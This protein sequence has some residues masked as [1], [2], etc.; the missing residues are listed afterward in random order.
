VPE[1]PVAK[2]TQLIKAA[3]KTRPEAEALK[4]EARVQ[5]A[6]QLRDVWA[7]GEGEAGAIRALGTL[8]GE[9]PKPKFE[10]PRPEF[11]QGDIDGLYNRIAE[12]TFIVRGQ[13]SAFKAVP[14]QS[15][16]TKLLRGQLPTMGE[17]QGL[18][19]VFG[20]E[21]A[22][23]VRSRLPLGNRAWREF[24]ELSGLARGVQ[25]AFD[26]SYGL[27]Q[28]IVA[29]PRHP[30]A[31]MNMWKEGFRQF[32]PVIEIRG[33]QPLRKLT[34][35]IGE[36]RGAERLAYWEGERAAGNI[37]QNLFVAEWGPGAA[38]TEREEVF[39]SRFLDYVPGIR[40]SNR[41][42]SGMGNELR[43]R[44]SQGVVN[45]WR[46]Q[47]LEIT[48]QMM[49]DLGKGIN[50]LS[51][52]GPIPDNLGQV[53]SGIFYAPRFV[54]SKPA[55]I[56]L[57]LNPSTS[58]QVRSMIA[59]EFV[60]FVGT[61]LGILSMVKLSGL[62][63]VE[64][65]PRSSDFGKIRLG[66]LRYDFWGGTQ[67]MARYA[68]QLITG[69]RKTIGTGELVNA[70]RQA[71]LGRFVQSKLSPQAGLGLDVWRGETF[72]GED[73]E[74]TPGSIKTQAWNRAAPMFI[75]DVVDAVK[76]H[77]ASAGI[78]APLSFFGAGV[79]AMWTPGQ[80]VNALTR[81]YDPQGRSVQEMS[82]VE[83][84]RLAAE[85]PD[86]AAARTKQTEASAAWGSEIAVGKQ[87]QT[88][89]DATFQTQFLERWRDPQGMTRSNFTDA[90]SDYLQARAQRNEVRY[91]GMD[92]DPRTDLE[93]RLDEYYGAKLPAVATPTEREQF[94]A[95]QDALLAADP[96]LALAIKDNQRL[97]FTDPAMQ[98]VVGQIWDAK[99]T[100]KQYY[101]IPAFVGLSADEADQVT[102]IV[103][104]A[105]DMATYGQA[106]SREAAIM[107]LAGQ[108][109][110]KFIMYALQ[111]EKLRNP[112]RKIFKMQHA[113]E[114]SWFSDLPVE[115]VD[116]FA[117]AGVS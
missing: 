12:H 84:K 115:G 19:E 46:R 82:A 70:S 66:K 8:K 93:R 55:W 10:P 79:Q 53:L 67:Q 45:G 81:K 117:M 14:V 87:E 5:Q 77:G 54:T 57:A 80:Q 40:M 59:Q 85:H 74:V 109:P 69:Q 104:Q 39:I 21:F 33:W 42:F 60:A 34:P 20:K 35:Y 7:A 88:A 1:D 36:A 65:D 52:R 23:A 96:E 72:M 111:A 114:L 2:L 68:A 27:R 71:V 11:G 112:E 91:A 94:F 107:L 64:A 9:L 38:F 47:G 101:A 50:Y 56:T 25:A 99:Q 29:A 106:P 110:Q 62:G 18:E 48:D 44:I 49:T 92:R 3:R 22:T 90:L 116:T 31:W 6:G 105:S 24:W 58:P 26:M 4:H 95:R 83:F 75:Q 61:G 78:G 13:P 43:G 28:G 108:Y 113:K 37:P 103:K 17:I 97:I 15:G 89:E 98:A 51:G 102:Q 73:V 41:A 32:A 100:R 16:L 63:D 76:I 86:L 30:T